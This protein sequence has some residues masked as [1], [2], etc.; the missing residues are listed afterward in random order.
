MSSPEAL[1]QPEAGQDPSYDIVLDSYLSLIQDIAEALE[2]IRPEIGTG[3][4]EQLIRLRTRLAFDA[5]G[6]TLEECR[7]ALHR[8]LQAYSAKAHQYNQ[9]L[10][11]DVT[12]TLSILAKSEDALSV[13]NDLYADRLAQFANHMEQ[14]VRACNLVRLTEQTA[15]LRGFVES[16]QQ[17]RRDALAR[18]QQKMGDF[19]SKLREAELLASLDPLTGVANRR[20]FDRQL[21]ERIASERGFCVLLFDLDH[22]KS[23]NDRFGHL[24]GDEVLRQLGARLGRHVRTRDFVCRWGGDEFVVILE[25]GLP[26]AMQRSRQIAQWLSGPYKVVVEGQETNVD[27]GVSVGVAERIANDTP[28]QLFRRVDGSMY[29]Q[30]HPQAIG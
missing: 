21:A 27:I 2:T 19:Q 23:V 20:E 14:A 24:C 12:Q 17:D 25:C 8:E 29:S 15:E 26:N 5:S 4:H 10:A 1:P 7:T 11:E 28:E 9:A 6:Q 18:L 22:F 13:R 16:M 3:C 30:K